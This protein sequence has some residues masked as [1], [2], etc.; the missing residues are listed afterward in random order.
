MRSLVADVEGEQG[1]G[2]LD[3]GSVDVEALATAVFPLDAVENVFL[4][5]PLVD[6][7]RRSRPGPDEEVDHLHTAHVQPAHLDSVHV[8]FP[9]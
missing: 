2:V 8:R 7:H 3:R 1:G 9:V 5:A 4:T 6:E